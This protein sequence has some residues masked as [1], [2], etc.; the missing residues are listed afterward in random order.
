MWKPVQRPCAQVGLGV[1]RPPRRRQ[2]QEEREIGG[3]LVEDAGR[4]AHRDPELGRGGDV[5]VVVADRDVGDDPQPRRAG[6]EDGGVDA[7]GEDAHDRVDVGDRVD[8][9]GRGQRLV[10]RALHQLVAGGD[11]RVE[12]AVG[13]RAGDED[14]GHGERSV[15]PIAKPAPGGMYVSSTR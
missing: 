2:Q 14:S 11:E 6:P 10:A 15:D 4:V 9:L 5:D 8:Q 1:G 3:R 7:V 13:Q 12:P